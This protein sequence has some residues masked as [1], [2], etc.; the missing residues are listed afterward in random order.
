MFDVLKFRRVRSRNSVI[1]LD[2]FLVGH[3]YHGHDKISFSFN[4]SMR[5]NNFKSYDS[6][7]SSRMVLSIFFIDLPDSQYVQTQP[8]VVGR[9]IPEYLRMGSSH[10]THTCCRAYGDAGEEEDVE[11]LGVAILVLF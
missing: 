5:L 10:H 8:V 1:L 3:E 9:S 2:R 7:G 4:H 11:A 6:S